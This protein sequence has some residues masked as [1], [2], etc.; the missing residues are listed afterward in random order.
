MVSCSFVQLCCVM[1]P[2]FWCF[3]PSLYP[4]FT[5]FEEMIF[6]VFPLFLTAYDNT[7]YIV[8]VTLMFMG[9]L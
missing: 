7:A 5:H 1:T 3:K 8:T 2:C 4:P 6:H 9:M